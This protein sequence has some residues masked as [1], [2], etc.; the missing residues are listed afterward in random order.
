MY[1]VAIVILQCSNPRDHVFQFCMHGGIGCISLAGPQGGMFAISLPNLS[2]H[3][4]GSL[5]YSVVVWSHRVIGE[6]Y[7]QIIHEMNYVV[8]KMFRVGF[9]K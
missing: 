6:K 8:S 2:V 9:K 5:Q 3:I 7:R 1:H 4:C